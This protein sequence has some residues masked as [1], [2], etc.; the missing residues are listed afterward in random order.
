[1]WR[2]WH[3]N[4]RSAFRIV[5][6]MFRYCSG[7]TNARFRKRE[8]TCSP[9]RWTTILWHNA[10]FA[11]ILLRSYHDPGTT[12]PETE[13]D[14]DGRDGFD[15]DRDRRRRRHHA[16]PAPQT[17][18]VAASRRSDSTTTG[19]TPGRQEVKTAAMSGLYFGHPR[20]RISPWIW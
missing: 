17:Y 14:R 4:E 7:S 2:F 20:R 16:P 10:V 18:S 1:M 3:S 11:S 13:T 12:E 8:S 9:F 5:S 19:E 15:P 6:W